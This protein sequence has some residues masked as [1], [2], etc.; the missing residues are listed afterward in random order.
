MCFTSN[1]CKNAT[2]FRTNLAVSHPIYYSFDDT[3]LDE[4]SRRVQH[5]A[6]VRKLWIV[7]DGG[8]AQH[9]VVVG[10]VVVLHELEEGLDG[11]SGP[12]IVGGGNVDL[13]N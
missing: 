1:I 8:L 7:Q 2:T 6:T 5:Y 4:V 9:D 3:R 10:D 11:V 12:K 13:T